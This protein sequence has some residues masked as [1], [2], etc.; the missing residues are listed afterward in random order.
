M[1]LSFYGDPPHNGKSARAFRSPK[2]ISI[3]LP[4]STYQQLVHRSNA[5]GRSMSN[6]ASFLL[7]NS[8]LH[9]HGNS[10]QP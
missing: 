2:R 10:I 5:E 4:D 9:L 8:L 7:D 3:T 1:A 6:L